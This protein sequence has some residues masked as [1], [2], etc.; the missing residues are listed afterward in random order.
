MSEQIQELETSFDIKQYS[1]ETFKQIF[2]TIGQLVEDATFEITNEGLTFRGMD[3]S[4]VCLIDLTMSNASFEKYEVHQEGKFA[5]RVNE[6]NKL[7]KNFNKKDSV[8]LYTKE[9]MLAIETKTS[10]T[11][12]RMIDASSCDCPVPKL[13]YN[14]KVGITTNAIKKALNQIKTVSDYVTLETINIRNFILSGKGNSGESTI[15]FERG[16]EEIPEIEVREESK[17]VYSLEYL[18]PFLRQLKTCKYVTL[19]YS[20]RQPLR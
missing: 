15:N 14:A 12:L 17:T 3:P 8:R 7:L 13:R 9:H 5:V 19:E 1:S 18:I 10:K 16:M 11:N 2:G 4:N 6:L 20:S